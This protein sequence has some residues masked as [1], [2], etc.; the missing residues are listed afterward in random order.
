LKYTIILSQDGDG[1]FYYS[2]FQDGIGR[3]L[4]FTLFSTR[5]KIED[6]I[7]FNQDK[8]EDLNIL[9]QDEDGRFH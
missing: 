6:S 8:E 9:I 7:I 2:L 3:L 4:F 1:R 5:I